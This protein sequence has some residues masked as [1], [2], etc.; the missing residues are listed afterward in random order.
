MFKNLAGSVLQHLGGL[1]DLLNG[2]FT[3][4]V[5]LIKKG[6]S[7]TVNGLKNFHTGA[8]EGVADAF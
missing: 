6:L 1:G 4:D 2:I 7:S 5:D 3:L 8:G